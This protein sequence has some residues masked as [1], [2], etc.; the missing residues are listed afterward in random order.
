[1]YVSFLQFARQIL[2]EGSNP[3]FPLP[4]GELGPL[5][6]IMLLAVTQVFPPNGISV[7]RTALPGCM[8]VTDG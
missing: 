8:S 5:F 2:R 3:Q 7:G 4:I 1:M 6:S